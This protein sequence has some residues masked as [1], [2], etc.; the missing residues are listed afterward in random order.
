MGRTKIEWQE[1]EQREQ[2]EM[3][4]DVLGL[5]TRKPVA[6]C[7]GDVGGMIRHL[8]SRPMPRPPGFARQELELAAFLDEVRT[9]G[10][11]LV[12]SPVADALERELQELTFADACFA[13]T[14]EFFDLLRRLDEPFGA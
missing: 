9:I 6:E 13:A 11:A 5:L 4:Q 10:E 12:A 14:Q 7:L 1:K 8:R 2:M 3:A